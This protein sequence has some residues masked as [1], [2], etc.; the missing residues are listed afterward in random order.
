MINSGA[1]T[2]NGG[3]TVVSK[4][5]PTIT[6][7]SAYAANDVVGGLLTLSPLRLAAGSGILQSLSIVDESNQ[8]AELDFI[9]FDA[10][11][12]SST[13]ANDGPVTIHV[14]DTAK[15]LG[16]VRVAA[17]DYTTLNAK[18]FAMKS[19]VGLPIQVPAG[20]NIFVVAVTPG[21]PTYTAA[22]ALKLAFGFLLD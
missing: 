15:V 10:S 1:N 18:A 14:N 22:T 20:Q 6:S 5:T 19:A 2:S 7:G 13:V 21:T 3:F 12:S 8:K 4:L 17:G 9:F 11:P 16:M